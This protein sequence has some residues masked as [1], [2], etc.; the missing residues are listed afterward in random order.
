MVGVV[1]FQGVGRQ[2]EFPE[3]RLLEN[4]KGRSGCD[5]VY[6]PSASTSNKGIE[7]LHKPVTVPALVPWQVDIQVLIKVCCAGGKLHI[8]VR[9]P[10]CFLRSSHA[11]LPEGS[12]VVLVRLHG[13]HNVLKNWLWNCIGPWRL[14]I[15]VCLDFQ[16]R[17]TCSVLTL[18]QD[19]I[20]YRF[21]F[22]CLDSY[23]RPLL[24]SF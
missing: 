12:I 18:V 7:S 24:S 14:L 6:G 19:A 16:R 17:N 22:S 5:V 21:V 9:G 2:A 1:G 8:H 11:L 13:A 3:A 10:I 15:E 23:S 4:K 20:H